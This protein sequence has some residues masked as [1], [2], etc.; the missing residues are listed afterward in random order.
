M[1]SGCQLIVLGRA[2]TARPQG[3][4][5]TWSRGPGSA[6]PAWARSSTGGRARCGPAPRQACAL[7]LRAGSPGALRP[8][9]P[10]APAGRWPGRS[11]GRSKRARAGCC[12]GHG[13]H[14]WAAPG[15]PRP[16]Q[17]LRPADPGQRVH[18]DRGLGAGHDGGDHCRH[19]HRRCHPG[20]EGPLPGGEPAQGCQV[21]RPVPHTAAK[22]C[23]G[24]A[25][26]APSAGPA[27]SLGQ[28][29]PAVACRRRSSARPGCRHLWRTQAA[30]LQAC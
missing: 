23:V 18:G 2:P 29:H 11:V 22:C 30:T 12:A 7:L 16:A 26:P 25:P 28:W 1:S 20:A 4:G 21:L 19:G 6:G 9:G 3:P 27:P 24:A 13:A 15:R 8:H 17:L 14:R 10:A 5:W